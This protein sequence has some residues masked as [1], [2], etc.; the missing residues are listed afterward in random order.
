MKQSYHLEDK[1][2]I[3]DFVDWK[4]L[5]VEVLANRE[6]ILRAFIAKHGFDPDDAEQ[7]V[8]YLP[9]GVHYYVRKRS[10]KHGRRAIERSTGG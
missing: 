10:K 8:E 7:V 9:N 3:G 5:V 4:Q 2:A 1:T 6:E